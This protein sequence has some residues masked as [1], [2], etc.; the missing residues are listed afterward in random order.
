[1]PKCF[2]IICSIPFKNGHKPPLAETVCP[3]KQHAFQNVSLSQMTITR[4][5]EEISSDINDQLNSDIEKYVCV[6]LALDEST[7]IGSTAQLLIFI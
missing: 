5:V 7:N 4:R 1:M 3:D 2:H 6:S